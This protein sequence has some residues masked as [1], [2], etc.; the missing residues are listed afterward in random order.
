MP[1]PFPGRC[2]THVYLK[3]LDK[4]T[5]Y[6]AGKDIIKEPAIFREYIGKPYPGLGRFAALSYSI[7]TRLPITHIIEFD[8]GCKIFEW[9]GDFMGKVAINNRLF[10]LYHPM[11]QLDVIGTATTLWLNQ[12]WTVL[13]NPVPFYAP[14]HLSPIKQNLLAHA[15][16]SYKA[17]S[18]ETKPVLKKRTIVFSPKPKFYADYK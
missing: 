16:A 13:R 3:F 9:V 17:L 2:P 7:L 4:P 1:M 10:S 18:A 8:R 12:P 5:V 11:V 6:D 15:E 14:K